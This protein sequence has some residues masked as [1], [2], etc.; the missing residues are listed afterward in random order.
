MFL[1][2]KMMICEGYEKKREVSGEDLEIRFRD[3]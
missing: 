1:R 2:E 3:C